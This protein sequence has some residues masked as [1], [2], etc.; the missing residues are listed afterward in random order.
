M[1]KQLFRHENV[2]FSLETRKTM[3][4]HNLEYLYSIYTRRDLM[5]DFIYL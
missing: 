1:E 3:N 2:L 5:N 4:K